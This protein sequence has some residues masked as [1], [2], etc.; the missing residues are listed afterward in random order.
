MTRRVINTWRQ[1]CKL[2][3]FTDIPKPDS[4]LKLVEKM[5]H[6]HW[7]SLYLYIYIYLDLNVSPK[8]GLIAV[9]LHAKSIDCLRYL[10]CSSSHPDHIKNSVIWD[11]GIFVLM[12]RN[13]IMNWWWN[14]VFSIHQNRWL[15][16]KWEKLNLA[17]R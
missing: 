12:K 2:S 16:Y 1:I 15:I 5:K 6:F 10:Q 14:H 7:L 13:L 11:W 4:W 8:D 3:V 9:D 17:K